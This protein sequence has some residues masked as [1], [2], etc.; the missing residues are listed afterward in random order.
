MARRI[1]SIWTQ[2]QEVQRVHRKTFRCLY[3]TCQCARW[4][5]II[6]PL[7]QQYKVEVMLDIGCADTN[8]IGPLVTV[9]DP[10]L[11]SRQGCT[12]R[13]IPHIY[14]NPSQPDLPYLCLFDPAN[15]EWGYHQYVATTT[16]LWT[17]DWLVCYEGWL[18]TGEWTGG[19][20]H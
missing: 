15:D 4:E 20:R 14:Q 13:G 10:R 12:T 11:R 8:Y 1:L 3:H 2:V 17:I 19:G 6:R 7:D 9:V 18:A 16:I 5:G